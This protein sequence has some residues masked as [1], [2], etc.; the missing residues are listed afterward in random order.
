MR[1]KAKDKKFG[2]GGKK[3]GSKANTRN[4]ADDISSYR[5]FPKNNKGPAKAGGKGKTM[6]AKLKQKRLGKSR[7]KQQGKRKA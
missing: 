5:P 6:G 2:F 3:K 7:R 4:S 1:R